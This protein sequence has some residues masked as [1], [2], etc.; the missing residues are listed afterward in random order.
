MSDA[1]PTRR[2]PVPANPAVTFTHSHVAERRDDGMVVELVHNGSGHE[3]HGLKDMGERPDVA[4]LMADHQFAALSA[5]AQVARDSLTEAHRQESSLLALAD[6]QARNE[7]L[8]EAAQIVRTVME[9]IGSA[10]D[11]DQDDYALSILRDVV[12]PQIERAVR[13]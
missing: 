12:L 1:I 3:Y 6:R 8:Q 10:D 4:S 13:S 5:V 7:G 11:I 2:G 9:S